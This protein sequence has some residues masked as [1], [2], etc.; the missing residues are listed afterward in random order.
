MG[1]YTFFLEY[2]GKKS[3]SSAYQHPEDIIVADQITEAINKFCSKNKLALN[4]YDPLMDEGYR[5]YLKE[6]KLGKRR[7]KIYYVEVSL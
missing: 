4:H 5:I 2:D 1:K 6:K 3:S 7:E